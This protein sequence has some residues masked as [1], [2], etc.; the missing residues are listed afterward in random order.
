MPREGDL[1]DDLYRVERLLGRGGMGEVW[2]A[3]RLADERR[4]ALK[5]LLE[6]AARSPDLV[7]RF[8]REAHIAAT[9]KSP[10]VCELVSAGRS[11]AGELYLVLELL[12][13]ETLAD[14][15]KREGDMS[16]S[17]LSPVVDDLLEGLR[18]AHG[19]GVVHRDLKPGNIFLPA[20]DPRA[21]AKILDF[22]ISKILRRGRA[23]EERSL[24]HLDATLGSFAYMA[25][26]QVRG[27]ARVDVRADLY[28]VGTVVFRAL[29]GRL[30][31]EATTAT[32]LISTKL[33]RDPPSLSEVTGEQWPSAI[34]RFCTASLA[35]D[36]EARFP[37][38]D[39]A[40][41]AWRA[42]STGHRRAL[43]SVAER[44]ESIEPTRTSLGPPSTPP[45]N[46][47]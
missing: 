24:T 22:G 9:V 33:E 39:A 35:R 44:A 41:A 28:A 31:F 36:R 1:F 27:A 18:I 10:F 12:T 47:D 45:D 15:L 26:E 29:A 21:H 38:A 37:T 5:L 32:M 43:A 6:K 25:P 3:V 16:F 23:S 14:Q 8:G 17:E 19:L 11:K 42:I 7:K 34:E 40:L 2:E 30:P 20:D 13:G 4:V 46:P